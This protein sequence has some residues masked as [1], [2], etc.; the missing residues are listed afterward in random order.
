VLSITGENGPDSRSYRVDFS[1]ARDTLGFEATWSVPD[2]AAELYGAISAGVATY[3]EFDQ[4]FTRLRRLQEL[5]ASGLL[6]ESMRRVSA[7]V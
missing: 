4:T 5:R 1:R 3:A 7:D 6:D 2:G